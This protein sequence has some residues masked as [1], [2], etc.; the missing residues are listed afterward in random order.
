MRMKHDPIVSGKRKAVNLSL[1]T[2]V[3]QTARDLGLNL[4]KISEDA[5]RAA[6]REARNRKWADEHAK[7]IDA[8]AEWLDEYGMPFEDLRVF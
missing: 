4:S 5:L 2:G 7:R 3:V 1:D 8:F 6:T